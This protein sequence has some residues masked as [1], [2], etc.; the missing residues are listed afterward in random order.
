M[1]INKLPTSI[2][3]RIDQIQRNFLWGT[4]ATKKK[5]HLWVIA[6]PF[7]TWKIWLNRNNNL[8]RN[9]ASEI[10]LDTSKSLT[11]EFLHLS[12]RL[13]SSTS[14]TRKPDGNLWNP[15]PT[16]NFK[17]NID[18]SFNINTKARGTCCIIRDK[19]GNWVT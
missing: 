8:Y 16:C 14:P 11:L 12:P 13:L 18:G 5:I 3:K 17:L 10:P 1:Q 15:P 7:F 19:H 4:T 6:F 2:T 9:T